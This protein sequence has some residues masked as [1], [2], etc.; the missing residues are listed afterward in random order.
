M[1]KIAMAV[2]LWSFLGSPPAKPSDTIAAIDF[3]GYAGL[4]VARV[5][6]ALPVHAGD[7]LTG[8][9]K[10]LIK[11]AVLGAVGKDPTD[12]AVIC[13]DAKGM[14]L[15]YIGLPG[16]SYKP[17]ALNPAPSG[18]EL[19]P[20]QI[21]KLD[22]RETDALYAEFKKGKAEEDDS[23]GY[24]LVKDPKARALELQVRRHMGRI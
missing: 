1:P 7:D 13:C 8:Q 2:L 16:E 20:K 19:L 17:F 18:A 14:S 22:G 10:D 21:V 5:R 4:D 6:A 9:T 24:V 15:L 3:F 12:V 23:Q 11:R